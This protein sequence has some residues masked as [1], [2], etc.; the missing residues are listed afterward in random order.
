MSMGM[1]A[2]FAT[3]GSCVGVRMMSVHWQSLIL[4]RMIVNRYGGKFCRVQ[5]G[6]GRISFPTLI[7]DIVFATRLRGFWEPYA[8]IFISRWLVH[9]C[10]LIWIFV[11][12]CTGEVVILADFNHFL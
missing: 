2:I 6:E 4:V 1:E 7:V 3:V 9:V 10:I 5:R 8:A 12:I 11:G